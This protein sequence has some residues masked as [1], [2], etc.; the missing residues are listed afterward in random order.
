MFTMNYIPL[1]PLKLYL[2]QIKEGRNK[3]I[4]CNKKYDN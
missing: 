2:L 1:F 3:I 4:K